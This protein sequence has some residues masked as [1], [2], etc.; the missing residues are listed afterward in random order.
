MIR[1]KVSW[2]EVIKGAEAYREALKAHERE[3]RR[4]AGEDRKRKNTG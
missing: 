2:K 3:L 1:Y 4:M